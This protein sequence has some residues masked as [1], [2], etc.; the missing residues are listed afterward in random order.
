MPLPYWYASGTMPFMARTTRTPVEP[1]LYLQQR[2]EPVTREQASAYGLDWQQLIGWQGLPR[3]IVPVRP[4][5]R[6]GHL[7]IDP[8]AVQPLHLRQHLVPDGWLEAPLGDGWIAAYRLV[9][10][11]GHPVLGELR[12]FPDDP[13]QRNAR[14]LPGRW[15]GELDGVTA[16]VPRGGLSARLLRQVRPGFHVRHLTAFLDQ[17]HRTRPELFT[18]GRGL[19]SIGFTRPGQ[20]TGPRRGRPSRPAIFYARL[21]AAYVASIE[22][23]SLHPVRDLARRFR[24]QPSQARD[25]VHQA[26]RRGFLTG[27]GKQGAL[28]GALTDQARQLLKKPARRKKK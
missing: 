11:D 4:G 2:I 19:A 18:P 20:R 1:R 16:R 7:T 5:K 23:G 26:R 22:R 27:S 17:L 12:I 13:R 6:P 25:A 3:Y 9:L 21:A 8:K 10:Q 14:K 15:R 28:G 24:L